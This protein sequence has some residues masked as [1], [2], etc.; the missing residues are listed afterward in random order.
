MEIG[1]IIGFE[2]SQQRAARRTG[3]GPV[4][5]A[6]V[7]GGSSG[8]WAGRA[9]RPSH[10]LRPGEGGGPWKSGSWR[11]L[12]LWWEQVQLPRM[13]RRDRVTVFLGSDGRVPLKAPCPTVMALYDVR[14]FRSQQA[15]RALSDWARIQAAHLQALSADLVLTG[16][17]WSRHVL[18]SQVG[19]APDKVVV[20]P[21]TIDGAFHAGVATEAV[22]SRYG[23]AEPYV[24]VMGDCSPQHNV[25]RAVEA[26]GR[27][28]SALRQ[29]YRLVLAGPRNAYAHALSRIIETW[30]CADRVRWIGDVAEADVPAVLA[31]ADLCL[32]PELEAASARPALEALACGTPVVA[33]E[34]GAMPEWLGTAAL[35]IDPEHVASMTAAMER[36]LL[37]DGLRR[38][39]CAEGALRAGRC[40]VEAVA[41]QLAAALERV[42][43]ATSEDAAGVPVVRS[44][45][46]LP[47]WS[48]G[49]A[50]SSSH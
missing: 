1:R 48:P 5:R 34:R 30:G 2:E 33:S 8:G 3:I 19:V 43:L 38:Q 14:V 46:G 42:V 13:M 7:Q 17:A 31:G 4:L 37:D 15:P 23:V 47:P 50:T 27:L 41:A 6:L 25:L 45:A 9:Y 49:R 35:W 18:I 36:G 11:P 12:C 22:R 21:E 40:R 26:Y 39:L 28:P 16:S 29:R 44:S 20:L 32:W 24:L 10:V